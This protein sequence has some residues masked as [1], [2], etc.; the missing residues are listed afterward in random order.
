MKN[1]EKFA[2]EII[3]TACSGDSI[4]VKNK[5]VVDKTKHRCYNKDS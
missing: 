5:K 4:A 3:E 2:K 1:K